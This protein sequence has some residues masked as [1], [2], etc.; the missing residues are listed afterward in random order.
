MILQFILGSVITFIGMIIASRLTSFQIHTQQ[1]AIVA[2]V[3]TA[4]GMVPGVGWIISLVSVFVLLKYFSN[5]S[6][7]ILMIIVSWLMSVLSVAAIVQLLS[8]A[9]ISL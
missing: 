9:S 8:K 6:G 1:I 4:L 5:S 2:V 7:V 3:S